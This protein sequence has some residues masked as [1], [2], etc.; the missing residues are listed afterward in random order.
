MNR[1]INPNNLKI[2]DMIEVQQA[3]EDERGNYHD[4]FA[5]VKSIDEKGEMTLEFE[6]VSPD[7]KAFLSHIDEYFAK[8]FKPENN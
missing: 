4:E 3:W 7:V 1:E 2:G 8:D 5:V 6:N